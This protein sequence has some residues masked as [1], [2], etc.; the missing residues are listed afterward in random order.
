MAGTRIGNGGTGRGC[1]C[2][3]PFEGSPDGRPGSGNRAK[4]VGSGGGAR[5]ANGE[6]ETEKGSVEGC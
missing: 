3:T 1:N 4:W 6:N 5:E 2:G